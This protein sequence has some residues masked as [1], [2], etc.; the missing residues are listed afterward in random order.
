MT[1]IDAVTNDL[2]T[3]FDG[4][5]SMSLT[6]MADDHGLAIT[7]ISENASNFQGLSFDVD[8]NNDGSINGINTL[9]FASNS[10]SVSIPETL[11]ID[12]GIDAPSKIMAAVS[13]FETGNLFL[14]PRSTDGTSDSTVASHVVSV[15]IVGV[16]V[17][18]LSEPIEITF[19]N[20][21]RESEA[22]VI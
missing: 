22:A 3:N 13:L 1:I 19:Q 14:V 12:L 21:M 17:F 15:D 18:N 9:P 20:L 8:T 5:M 2:L 4:V 11:F 6:V 16:D 10:S 7:V